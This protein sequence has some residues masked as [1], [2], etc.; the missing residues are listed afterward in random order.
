MSIV[1]LDGVT[2]VQLPKAT[3]SSVDYVHC[4]C[5]TRI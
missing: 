3:L 2:D 4:S 5:R 1:F